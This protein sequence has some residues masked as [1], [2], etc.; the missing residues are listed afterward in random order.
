[1]TRERALWWCHAWAMALYEESDGGVIP[2][3][4]HQRALLRHLD[5]VRRYLALCKEDK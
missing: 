4:R 3:G 1:M 2:A 5:A